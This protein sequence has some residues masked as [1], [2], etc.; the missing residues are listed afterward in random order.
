[1]YEPGGDGVLV[2]AQAGGEGLQCGLAAGGRGGH[3]LLEVAAAAFGHD[4]GEG[5]DVAG[6]GEQLRRGG[7][8]GLQSGLV[9]GVPVPVPGGPDPGGDHVLVRLK[10]HIDDAAICLI[11]LA[12]CEL[13]RT[14]KKL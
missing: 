6:E 13:G 11:T 5:A 14:A 7:K 4:G 8:E 10:F 1:M 2:G 9:L 3:P 12:I